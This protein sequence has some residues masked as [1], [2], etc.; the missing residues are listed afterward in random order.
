MGQCEQQCEWARIEW[1]LA[2]ERGRA[3]RREVVRAHNAAVQQAR[4][5]RGLDGPIG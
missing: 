4:Y 5:A 2:R 3:E 1:L